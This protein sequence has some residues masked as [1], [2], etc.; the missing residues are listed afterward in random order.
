MAE[1]DLIPAD[2]ARRQVLRRRVRQL[3]TAMVALAC[4]LV[5]ARAT[6]YLLTSA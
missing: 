2:Y 5:L 3:F 1:L 4:L 6:L